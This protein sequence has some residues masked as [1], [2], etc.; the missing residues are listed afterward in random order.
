MANICVDDELKKEADKKFSLIGM[1]TNDGVNIFLTQF[2]RTGKFPFQIEVPTEQPN[3]KTLAAFTE[4]AQI[5]SQN[6][7]DN[8]EPL[9]DYRRRMRQEV[10]DETGHVKP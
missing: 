5:L 3:D 9:T 2:V 7:S 10:I 1:N 8:K 4:T 6:H